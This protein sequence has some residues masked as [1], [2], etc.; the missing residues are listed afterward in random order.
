MAMPKMTRPTPRVCAADGVSP[1][2]TRASPTVMTGWASRMTLT[3]TAGSRG[4][5]IEMSR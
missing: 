2:R 1:I 4:S 3:M 5:E